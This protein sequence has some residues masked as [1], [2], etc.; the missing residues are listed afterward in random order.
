MN[1]STRGRLVIISGPSGAGKTTVVRSLLKQCP[2]PLQLSVSATT[3]PPRDGEEHGV[4]Y[5][6]L[7]PEQFAAKRRAGEFLE[8]FE[9][10]GRGYWYGTL[11]NEVTTS[12]AAGDWVI[13]EIDVQGALAVLGEFPDAITLFLRPESLDELER[14]LRGRGTESEDTI[15]QRLRVA[16]EELQYVNRYEYDII[17]QTVDQSVR[18]ICRVLTNAEKT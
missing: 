10:F 15:Q 14:R 8:C 11:R 2:L 3:R 6:F 1:T 4:D 7:T 18:D 17:N 5:Y 12:L 16:R 13:L 9:V